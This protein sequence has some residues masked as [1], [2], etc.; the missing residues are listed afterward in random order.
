MYQCIT[1]HIQLMR[2]SQSLLE[3][4]DSQQSLRVVH[5][6]ENAKTG[7]CT[8]LDRSL[9]IRNHRTE[10]I[11]WTTKVRLDRSLGGYSHTEPWS[12][13]LISLKPQL[14]DFEHLRIFAINVQRK[15]DEYWRTVP[16]VL[17]DCPTHLVF[18]DKNRRTQQEN[19]HIFPNLEVIVIH[20]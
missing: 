16:F 4:V 6:L 19:C 10:Q 14:I 8:L 9:E 7:D 1:I 17:V 11:H 18:H 5:I 15:Y 12:T 2:S 13:S 20:L 3:Q